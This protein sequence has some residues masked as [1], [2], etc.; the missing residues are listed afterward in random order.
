[1]LDMWIDYIFKET[2][3]ESLLQYDFIAISIGKEANSSLV[4]VPEEVIVHERTLEELI[5][6][7]N[8]I[9]ELPKV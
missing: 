5:L 1:M 9:S 7:S 2:D 8:H 6:S 4:A 3:L